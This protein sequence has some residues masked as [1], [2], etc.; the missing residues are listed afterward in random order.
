MTPLLNDFEFLRPAFLLLFF[1]IAFLLIALKRRVSSFSSWERTCDAPLLKYLVTGTTATSQK[2]R[3]FWLF[4]TFFFA[5]IAL[6][7]PSFYKIKRPAALVQNPLMVVL[8]LENEMNRSDIRPSR[9]AHAKIEITDI[10]QKSH[11]TPSGLVVF[12][13]EPFVVS[14]LSED[15][16]ILINLLSAVQT[17]IMPLQGNRLDRA[18]DLAV[19]RLSQSKQ[20][21]GNILVLTSGQIKNPSETFEAV[22]K[23]YQQGYKVSVYDISL[24]ENPDLHRLAETGG[25]KYGGFFE[26]DNAIISDFIASFNPKNFDLSENET[27]VAE[28]NGWFFVFFSAFGL[29]YFF[30]KGVI[31]VLFLCMMVKSSYAGFLLNAD[32][33]GAH[34][35]AAQKY[36][37]AAEK[38]QNP[39][40]KAAALYKAGNYDSAL[41]YLADKTDERS[42][43][44]KG[45]TLAKSGDYQNAINTYEEV[46]KMNPQNEDARFNLEY[47]KQMQQNNQ[48][49]SSNN[50][51]DQNEEQQQQQ[52]QQNQDQDQKQKQDQSQ[53]Q[54]QEEQK[55]QE[56]NQENKQEEK[57]QQEQNQKQNQEQQQQNQQRGQNSSSESDD[58][59]SKQEKEQNKKDDQDKKSSSSKEQSQSEQN[60][61]KD[62]TVPNSL[63]QE[64]QTGNKDDKYDET[65]QARMQRFRE[66][67]EDTGGLLKALIKE[68]YLKKRY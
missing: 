10:L 42:L 11:A 51:S 13:D 2:A 48:S 14:P 53:K 21:Q 56:Q 39:D 15:T 19:N 35:F 67:K 40:W 28:D 65:I 9:L 18:I 64:A 58:N 52:Q 54:D 17:D 55:Q 63:N 68:E 61:S 30:R 45:N 36:D 3:L 1:P 4:W 38:F 44:N 37:V 33:E 60:E 50:S 41:Q 27:T 62:Q 34:A 49:A 20:V 6:S 7:G 16:N 5:V 8:N 46:L 12:T 29:L 24:T 31:L 59:N 25:G 47:L 43:Y 22:K 26:A 66:I 23:A 32:Q 57:E